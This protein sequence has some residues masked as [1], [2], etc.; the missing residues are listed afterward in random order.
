MIKNVYQEYL[1][2]NSTKEI[3]VICKNYNLSYKK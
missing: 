1:K 2:T 3:L